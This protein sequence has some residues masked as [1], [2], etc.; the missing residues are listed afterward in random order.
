MRAQDKIKTI[1][2]VL[3]IIE[4]LKK[5]GKTVVTTNGSFDILH[6]AHVKI[7]E[8]ARNQGDALILLL[9][10]DESIKLNKGH[11]RPYVP[12]NDRA[13]IVAGLSSVDYVVIFP[14]TKPLD[15]LGR[16]KPTVHVKG[17]SVDDHRLDE[18]RNFVQSWGG[19]YVVLPL[20]DGY[21]STRTIE[22]ITKRNKETI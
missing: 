10:G 11:P 19:R 6:K 7:I 17:G 20:E 18:E 22:T 12:E 13:Y 3:P 21:S 8:D 2:E 14:E 1:G 15:Y 4:D 5:E 16:I 9:N